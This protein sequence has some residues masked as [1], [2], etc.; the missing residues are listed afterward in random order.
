MNSMEK[1]MLLDE[2]FALRK[3]D[4]QERDKLLEKLDRMTEQL[5]NLN[6]SS[7]MLMKQ[8]EEMKQM[9]SD[10]DA[11]I[12]KLQKENAALKEQKKL[13]RKNLYGSK[14]Q[15]TSARKRDTSSREEDKDDFDGSS[16]PGNCSASELNN[17]SQPARKEKRPYRKGMSYKRMKADKSV[18]HES[19]LSKLP[20]DA[21]RKIKALQSDGYNVHMYLDNELVDTEHICCM[22]HARAKFVYAF[23]QSAD[24]D[25]K[26]IIDCIGELYGLEEQYKKGKLSP[27]QITQCR[28]SMKTMEII[29]RIRSKLDALTADNHP[30]RGELMEKAV[31]YLKNFWKQLFNYL[32]DGRYS[33][34]NSIA[35]RF[36]RPLAGERKNSLFFG[37]SRMANVSAAYHT[38]ISTCRMNGIS[39]LDYLKKFFR[40]IVNGRRDYENLL[41]MTIGINTNK[42]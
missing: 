14:S 19:D 11:L 31:N 23:E 40:E 22:A 16:T 9:L 38:L 26:Y 41:P 21:D 8:N 25:A 24:K 39:A 37:S 12:A 17:P 28:Q 7:R 18:C 29:G 1:S 20:Q 6:E 27:E 33:I 32:K 30:P 35:E 34:D 2:L 10:R 42:L 15:K 13:D 3:A 4:K 5:L 36:I